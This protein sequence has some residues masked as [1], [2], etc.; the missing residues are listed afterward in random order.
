MAQLNND[1]FVLSVTAVL[2]ITGAGTM[3]ELNLPQSPPHW[4]RAEIAENFG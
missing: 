4:D 1:Y 3:S 2:Y